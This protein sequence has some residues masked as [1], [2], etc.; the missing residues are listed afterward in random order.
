MN[1]RQVERL[2]RAYMRGIIAEQKLSDA[3]GL[4]KAVAHA[5][6]NGGDTAQIEDIGEQVSALLHNACPDDDLLVDGL[7]CFVS[8]IRCRIRIQEQVVKVRRMMR[9]HNQLKEK[10]S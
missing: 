5:Q 2:A 9:E 3:F 10:Q 1:Q 7:R 8:E 6:Q 4:S